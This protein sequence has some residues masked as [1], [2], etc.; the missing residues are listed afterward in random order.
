MFKQTFY[1]ALLT[2]IFAAT[3]AMAEDK[4]ADETTNHP[5]TEMEDSHDYRAEDEMERH[6]EKYEEDLTEN[7]TNHPA[8]EMEGSH[9]PRAEDEMERHAEKYEEDLTDNEDTKPSRERLKDA[10]TSQHPAHEMGEGEGLE[11]RGN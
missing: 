1:T 9:D 11:E 10:E 8:S 7:E 3:P 2:S 6:A 5:A 4:T